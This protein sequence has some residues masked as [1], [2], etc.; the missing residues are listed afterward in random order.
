VSVGQGP[1]S[2]TFGALLRW[3]RLALGLSQEELAN[4][5]GLSV[6]AIANMERDRTTRPHRRSVQSLGDALGLPD[7]QRR[8]L[9]RAARC[10]RAGLTQAPATDTKPLPVPRQMPASVA[11]FVGR[12]Q[13]LRA[14]TEISEE[15]T[16]AGGAVVI[17]SIG[18]TAGVGKTA[19]AVHWAHQSAERFPDGQLYVNLQGYDLAGPLT[20]TQALAG[21]LAALGVPAAD[22]PVGAQQ[23][24]AMYRSMLAGRRLLVVLDNANHVEQVRPLLPGSPGCMVLVTSRDSLPGLVARDGARR[25]I[26]ELLPRTEAVTLLRTLVGRRVEAE[27]AAAEVLAA[28]CCRLPLALR[29]AA[30]LAAARPAAKLAD[31]VDELTGQQQRLDLLHVGN[32]PRATV[33]TVFSWS[34]HYLQPDAA[35]MFRLLGSHPGAEFDRYSGA[36]LAGIPPEAA[37]GVLEQLTRAHLI[38]PDGPIRYR[39]HDLLRAYARELA[40]A[41]QPEAVHAALTRLFDYY[42][43]TASSAMDVLFPAERGRRPPVTRPAIPAQPLSSEHGARAWLDVERA[44][45]VAAMAHMTTTGRLEKAVQLAATL[46]RYLDLGGHFTDAQTVHAHARQAASQLGDHAAEATSLVNLGSVSFRQGRHSQAAGYF[47]QALKLYGK[48]DSLRGRIRAL[49]NLGLANLELGNHTLA[50]QHFQDSLT[51]ADDTGEPVSRARALS[52]LGVVDIKRGNYRQARDRLEQALAAFRDMGDS[53]D[54]SGALALL[55]LTDLR[56]HAP[57]QAAARARQALKL[58]RKTGDRTGEADALVLLSE[59]EL[60]LGAYESAK[61]HITRSLLVHR[62]IGSKS[63]ESRALNV[64]GDLLLTTGQPNHARRAHIGALDISSQTGDRE[65]EARSNASLAAG[66]ESTGDRIQANMHWQRAL[67]LYTKLHDPM[68]RQIRERIDRF[69]DPACAQTRPIQRQ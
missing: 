27:P 44:N 10:L 59:A 32:D 52:H 17:S 56:Q 46:F 4:Q 21:F 40:V 36:A 66:Y 3:H 61:S 62:E 11:G 29:V 55:A 42:L 64:L 5:C 18:G 23:L 9:D 2:D 51:L 14:L 53:I 60:Q 47:E 1:P 57:A 41:Q 58:Y 20:V 33:R 67:N 38:E 54:E 19:L 24:A 34:Y 65:E 63:G 45:L 28:R 43:Y 39:M 7:P 8:Q 48:A 25:L 69:L 22:M 13:E 68:A 35:E 49:N 50:S 26:V 16:R 6:R 37:R 12:T 15:V 30:E 31:L